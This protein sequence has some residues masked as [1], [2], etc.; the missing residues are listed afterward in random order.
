MVRLTDTVTVAA[1]VED[2]LR[3]LAGLA[4]RPGRSVAVDLGGRRVE[5]RGGVEV[6]GVDV[7]RGRAVLRSR[8]ATPPGDG[9]LTATIAASM[10]PGPGGTAVTLVTDLVVTGRDADVGRAVLPAAGRRVV[11]ELAADL[12]DLASPR[13]GVPGAADPTRLDPPV[14]D[15]PVADKAVVD[16]AGSRDDRPGVR[17]RRRWPLVLA[18]SI[19]L[20]GIAAACRRRQG[21]GWG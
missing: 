6:L 2:C 9:W 3:S 19:A 5:Y 7:A 21:R 18:G 20:A 15:Q 1:P 13:S 17:S 4:A 16:Q 14:V 11:A 10:R 12:A 8:A